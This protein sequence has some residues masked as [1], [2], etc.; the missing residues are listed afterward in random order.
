MVTADKLLNFVG[1]F[2]LCGN[3]GYFQRIFLNLTGDCVQNLY[4]GAFIFLLFYNFEQNIYP[5]QITEAEE[6]NSHVCKVNLKPKRRCA[7]EK[8]R[9]KK[10]NKNKDFSNTTKGKKDLSY[11]GD[12]T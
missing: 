11:M 6:Q 5:K 9:K 2:L 1:N 7:Q 8:G 4:N 10:K 12:F 3:E